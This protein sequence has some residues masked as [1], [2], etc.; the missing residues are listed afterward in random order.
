M[1]I[2]HTTTEQYIQQALDNW[3]FLLFLA[4]HRPNQ[5][6]WMIT[7]QYYFI[8]HLLKAHLMSNNIV[9]GYHSDIKREIDSQ[10]ITDSF[11][12]RVISTSNPFHTHYNT[13]EDFSRRAR[14]LGIDGYY[15]PVND[16]ALID[17]VIEVDI[18]LE[19]FLKSHPQI[20]QPPF[21]ALGQLADIKFIAPQN[22]IWQQANFTFLT[23]KF[24]LP[25]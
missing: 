1:A 7:V 9:A 19:H 21:D 18:L 5:Y 11:L 10:K 12:L 3:Q 2:N 4:E 8:L 14:Y 15:E 23:G 16:K 6:D 20:S 24:I 13:L 17:A 25:S 22:S